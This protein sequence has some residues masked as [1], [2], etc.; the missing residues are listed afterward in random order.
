MPQH[1]SLEL[2]NGSAVRVHSL[3]ALFLLPFFWPLPF[4]P[5]LSGSERSFRIGSFSLV[6][7]VAR[8][9]FETTRSE[10]SILLLLQLLLT[11]D[12]WYTG[13]QD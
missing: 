4:P 11:A 8:F 5:S 12:S 2:E 1:L 13:A 7:G 3:L 9:K 10:W 6:W